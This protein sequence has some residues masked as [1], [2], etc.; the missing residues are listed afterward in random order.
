MKE[1]KLDNLKKYEK[2]LKDLLTMEPSKKR[3]NSFE[4]YKAFLLRDLEK[5]TKKI[6]NLLIGNKE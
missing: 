2:K 5:T 3:E 1:K 4:Q 6:N